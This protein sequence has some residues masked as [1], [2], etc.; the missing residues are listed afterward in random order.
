MD[1]KE[2]ER[3]GNNNHQNHALS[4][5][6]AGSLMNHHNNAMQQCT[7]NYNEYSG[8]GGYYGNYH[9]ANQTNVNIFQQRTGED[10]E[11]ANVLADICGV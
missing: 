8:I 10:E 3:T 2:K 6:V 5:Q 11:A 1:E 7:N 4:G 9:D